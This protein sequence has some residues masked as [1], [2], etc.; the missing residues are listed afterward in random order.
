[1]LSW[2]N[3]L[4]FFSLTKLI[5]FNDL[6]F[7]ML[8]NF[9]LDLISSFGHFFPVVLCIIFTLQS[10]SFSFLSGFREYFENFSDKLGIRAEEEQESSPKCFDVYTK[11]LQPV[12]SREFYLRHVTNFQ[13]IFWVN[14]FMIFY[15]NL[16]FIFL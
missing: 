1:M 7:F 13:C 16:L 9:L 11:S 5:E 2:F 6:S 10:S 3:Q 15:L 4:F 8:L 14:I 12:I